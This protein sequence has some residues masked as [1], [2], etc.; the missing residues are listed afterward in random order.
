MD[1]I[2]TLSLSNLVIVSTAALSFLP[3]FLYVIRQA[4]NS[5]ATTRCPA[6]LV[7]GEKLQK[8]LPG[9]NYIARLE[10][11]LAVCQGRAGCSVFI[12]GGI[13]GRANI[14]ESA[15][16]RSYFQQK[17]TTQTRITIEDRSRHTLE[18]LHNVR[19]LLE[20]DGIDKVAIITNRFHLARAGVLASGLSLR[21]E[22]CAAEDKFQHSLRQWLALFKEAY[23]IHWY[24]TGKYWSILTRN[25]ASLDRLS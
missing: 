14:S 25:Q 20:Q 10:R 4:I 21:F 6:I 17:S 9:T 19:V 23:F 22:L 5:P 18:N 15:C 13:T 3:A 7:L 11:A 12:V 2:W 24:F 16:G 8:D 1:G